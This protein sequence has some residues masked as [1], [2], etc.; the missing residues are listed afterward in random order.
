[1]GQEAEEKDLQGFNGHLSMIKIKVIPENVA[2]FNIL[3]AL[4]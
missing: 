2:K 3:D 4:L 1:M